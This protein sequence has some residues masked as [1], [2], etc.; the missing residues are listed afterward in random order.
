MDHMQLEY[1]ILRGFPFLSRYPLYEKIFKFK[2]YRNIQNIISGEYV[3]FYKVHVIIG[4]CR[5]VDQLRHYIFIA[6]RIKL[7]EIRNSNLLTCHSTFLFSLLIKE[8]TRKRKYKF[9]F[10]EIFLS[11]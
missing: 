5:S 10:E 6:V 7:E 1:T 8:K 2:K 4:K 3:I 9:I 11:P